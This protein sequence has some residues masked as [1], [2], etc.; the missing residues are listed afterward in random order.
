MNVALSGGPYQSRQERHNIASINAMSSPNG[1]I[2]CPHLE[3]SSPSRIRWLVFDPFVML[4]WANNWQYHYREHGKS[5]LNVTLKNQYSSMLRSEIGLRCA[6]ILHYE[7]G[8]LIF[9]E[10]GSYVNK[11]P[12]GQGTNTAAFVGA[13]S[14]FSVETFSAR[15]QNLGMI[16]IQIEFLPSDDRYPYG[17]LSYQGEFGSSFQ[18]QFLE[19]ET[20]LR[21]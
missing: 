6:E 16:Q 4:D 15:I 11:V 12:F 7:W 5:G 13:I 21:F 2:L 19:L 10:K 1:W 9:E 14:T 8:Q 3:F 18:S 17:S 20:G